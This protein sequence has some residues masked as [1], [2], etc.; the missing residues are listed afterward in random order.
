MTADR[1]ILNRKTID[2]SFCNLP[3]ILFESRLGEESTFSLTLTRNGVD[4]IVHRQ[5]K[6]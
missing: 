2:L 5:I 3:P 1:S 6:G 4:P